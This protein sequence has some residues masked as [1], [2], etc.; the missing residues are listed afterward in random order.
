M[1]VPMGSSGEFLR[2]VPIGGYFVR[3]TA[4][5]QSLARIGILTAADTV[6]AILPGLTQEFAP[7]G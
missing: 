5:M 4:A 7:S 6:L 1:L 2:G 3:C